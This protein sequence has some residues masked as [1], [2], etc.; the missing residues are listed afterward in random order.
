MGIGK[1][2][3]LATTQGSE[4]HPQIALDKQEIEGNYSSSS[5][6]ESMSGSGDMYNNGGLLEPEREIGTSQVDA[7]AGKRREQMCS[8]AASDS[9]TLANHGGVFTSF[10]HTGAPPYFKA[11][12]EALS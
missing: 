8:R 10:E 11:N 3:S 7:E 5:E 2:P 6:S 9:C 4:T 12:K 1:T